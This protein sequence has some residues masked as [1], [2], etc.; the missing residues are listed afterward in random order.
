VRLQRRLLPLQ[1]RLRWN[2]IAEAYVV[3]GS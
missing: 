2:R 1:D 3:A